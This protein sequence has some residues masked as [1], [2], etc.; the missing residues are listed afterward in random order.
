MVSIFE[1]VRDIPF[2]IPSDPA[3]YDPAAAPSLILQRGRGS[4]AAKHFLLAEMYRKLNVHVVFATF[5]FLWNDPGWHYPPDLRALSARLPVAYHL[6]C[7][8]QAGC[9]WVLVDAT[10]DRP[11]QHAGF[12]VNL[13]WDGSSEMRCAVRPLKAPM[14]TAFCRTEGNGPCCD[15]DA[16]GACPVNGEKDCWDA[17]DVVHYL[18]SR[19]PVRTAEETELPAGFYQ[20]FNSWLRSVR[21]SARDGTGNQPA[22]G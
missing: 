21:A 5:A 19:I 15:E 20:A 7:R 18:R 11:L 22:R 3:M 8:V 4:C 6:T 2:E 10:W 12:P 16:D 9:R 14:R 13:H 1:H 17:G